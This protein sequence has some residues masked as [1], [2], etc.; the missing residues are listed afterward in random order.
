MRAKTAKI[1]QTVWFKGSKENGYV[2]IEG[3]ITEICGDFVRVIIGNSLW[4]MFEDR[5]H[6]SKKDVIG[7][8]FQE[9]VVERDKLTRQLAK[10]Q[11]NLDSLREYSEDGGIEK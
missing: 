3:E 4:A 10:N 11:R 6:E 2:P 8:M 9:L 5:L 1:G 7:L